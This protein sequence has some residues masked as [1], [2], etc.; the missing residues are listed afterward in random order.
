MTSTNHAAERPFDPTESPITLEHPGFLFTTCQVGAEAALKH[1]LARLWPSFRF[2]FSRPGF[3]T[4]KLP[5]GHGLAD[6]FDLRSVFA[7]ASGFSIGRVS[8]TNPDE[9]ARNAWHLFG[10]RPAQALHVWQRDQAAPGAHGYEPDI[11][12]AACEAR[13]ALLRH[14]GRDGLSG[15]PYAVA[16]PGQVVVDCVVVEPDQWWVGFHRARSVASRWP[17]GMVHLEPPADMVSRAWFKMEEALRWSELP[18]PAGARCAEIGSAPGGASQALLS[19]GLEVIGIDPAEMDQR[20]LAMPGF[21]H[22]RRRSH[23]VRRRELRKVRWLTA[24]MNVAPPYTLEVVES[25][26]THPLVNVRGLLLTLKLVD[27]GLAEHLPDYLRQI[28]L[29]GYNHVGARQLQHNRQEVC[30]WALQQPFHRKPP[31]LPH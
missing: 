3:L 30:V 4:F 10:S 26:V 14:S 9:L 22:L 19:R 12:E 28:R 16:Q 13:A 20:V 8:G 23:E 21:T 5:E 1:E 7:R 15:S 17:G 24:D 18:I 11:T 27:W 31:V 2:A 6:D 25:I 29:W